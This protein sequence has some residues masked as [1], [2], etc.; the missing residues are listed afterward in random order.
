MRAMRPVVL[1]TRLQPAVVME[2]WKLV[3]AVVG[4]LLAAHAP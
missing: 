4:G 3:F 1:L 2:F